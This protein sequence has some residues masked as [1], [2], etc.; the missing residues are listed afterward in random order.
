M[1]KIKKTTNVVTYGEDFVVEGFE[2]DD[3]D[4]AIDD[5]EGLGV[6]ALGER[7]RERHLR[8]GED[9]LLMGLLGA[10]DVGRQHL[11][12]VALE[13]E[14]LVEG[15]GREG[16]AEV[17]HSQ[18]ARTA[19]ILEDLKLLVGLR[20]KGVDGLEVLARQEL[21][22]HLEQ[23]L[24]VLRVIEMKLERMINALVVNQISASR[25]SRRSSRAHLLHNRLVP[26]L[27][28]SM[29]SVEMRGVVVVGR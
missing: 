21:A 27:W 15:L 6:G 19:R 26:S 11:V 5:L 3:A 18:I 16:L 20:G 8:D 23:L 1:I 25:R 2:I 14:L 28:A 17:L 13:G 24:D 29:R 12:E 9:E 22:R 4:L 7:G 10:L